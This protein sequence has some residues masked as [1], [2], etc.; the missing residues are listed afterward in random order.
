[1]VITMA[2]K[3]KSRKKSLWA[4]P[5]LPKKK[6]GGKIKANRGIRLL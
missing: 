5:K 1:M 3:R 2:K 6:Q 4:L